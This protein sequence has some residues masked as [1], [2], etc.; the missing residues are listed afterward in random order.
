MNDKVKKESL[1]ISKESS[2]HKIFNRYCCHLL[3]MFASIQLSFQFI[4]VICKCNSIILH[5]VLFVLIIY[6]CY[7]IFGTVVNKLLTNA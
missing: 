3:S 2:F 5:K 1:D 7:D 6:N 4:V